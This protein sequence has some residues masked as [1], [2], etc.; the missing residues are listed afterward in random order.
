M[1]T[2][3]FLRVA[4]RGDQL[5]MIA[6]FVTRVAQQAGLDARTIY[7]IETAVDEACANIIY[8][9]YEYEGQGDI[10]L[11]CAC[12]NDEFIVTLTDHGRVFDPMS[13]PTPDVNAP[14]EARTE[15][16]LGCF[17]M[18]SLM[19]EVNYHFTPNANILTM[20]KYLT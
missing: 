11:R 10:E 2:G 8:H 7:H 20:V 16:G 12:Q 19:D 4:A 15:G 13:I 9:A 18:Q 1:D 5:A 3:Y 6:D 14:L 17:L